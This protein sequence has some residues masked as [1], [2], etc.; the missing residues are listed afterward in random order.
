MATPTK[1]APDATA[2]GAPINPGVRIGHVHLKVADIDRALAF[3]CGVLGFELTQRVGAPENPSHCAPRP[4][5][6]ILIVW[7]MISISRPIEAFL[8]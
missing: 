7:N 5:S 4:S 8:M 6:T 1:I 3:Y 2:A